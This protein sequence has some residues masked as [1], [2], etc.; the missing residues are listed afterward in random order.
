MEERKGHQVTFADAWQYWKEVEDAT[1]ASVVVRLFPS[2]E[3]QGGR[4]YPARLAATAARRE[5]KAV[6][7]R[8]VYCEVGTARGARTVPAALIRALTQLATELAEAT[9]QAVRQASF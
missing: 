3:M 9:D 6:K 1:G 7:E 2:R 8:T 5:G 4:S